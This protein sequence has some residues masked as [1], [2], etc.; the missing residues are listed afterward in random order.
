MALCT[1]G[2]EWLDDVA[3]CLDSLGHPTEAA[4]GKNWIPV[5]DVK[6]PERLLAR[7]WIERKGCGY[8]CH[9][10]WTGE[11]ADDV[12]R[13]IV[14]AERDYQTRDVKNAIIL[15]MS[16]PETRLFLLTFENPDP[17]NPDRKVVEAISL[18]TAD[19]N[20]W[21]RDVALRL[22]ELVNR[23]PRDEELLRN[24]GWSPAQTAMHR[25]G[26]FSPRRFS[27]LSLL[28]LSNAAK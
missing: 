18:L 28:G 14:M 16:N 20:C 23:L 9:G 7:F 27:F 25:A 1:S 11:E 19:R 8:Y 4:N 2:P 24:E 6:Q 21:S 12:T 22:R 15:R 17:N 5:V 26:A 13:A 10:N 3:G